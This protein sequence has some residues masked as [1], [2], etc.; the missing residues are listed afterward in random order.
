MKIDISMIQETHQINNGGWGEG[1]YTF[2]MTAE[3][4]NETEIE[5]QKEIKNR[6]PKR[7][8]GVA[9]AIANELKGNIIGIGGINDS[10]M[11]IRLTTNIRG[12]QI[13]NPQYTCTTHVLQ[14][15]RKGGILGKSRRNL[16]T[17]N[18]KDCIILGTDNNG[19]VAQQNKGKQ[20][21]N[22]SVGRWTTAKNTEQGNGIKLVDKCNKC[23]LTIMNTMFTPKKGEKGKLVT[24]TSGDGG[25]QRHLDYIISEKNKNWVK[26]TETRGQADIN[27]MYQRGIVRME[28]N[29]ALKKQEKQKEGNTSH[30]IY[31]N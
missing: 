20:G 16:K 31:K 9:I 22:K 3:R 19:Q 24:C 1:E 25:A 26:K 29:I 13:T 5:K 10:I 7:D 2:Y 12:R 21:I 14:H 27:Q 23:N 11:K 6:K 28:I 8:R 17:T 18:V 4:K 30:T 15:G